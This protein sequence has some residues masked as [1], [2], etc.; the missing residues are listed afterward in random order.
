MVFVHKQNKKTTF[1]VE[2][3]FITLRISPPTM[4]TELVS[5]RGIVIHSRAIVLGIIH[6]I[7][8]IVSGLNTVCERDGS[9]VI[10][11][12]VACGRAVA[13][14]VFAANIFLMS[15]F[16]GH[17]CF[18]TVGA[19]VHLFVHRPFFL[20]LTRR[21]VRL[22]HGAMAVLCTLL[23]RYSNCYFLA[24]GGAAVHCVRNNRKCVRGP[25]CTMKVL[26][27]HLACHKCILYTFAANY[28]NWIDMGEKFD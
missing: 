22:T 12:I 26:E 24:R 27:S 9:F 4:T 28:L 20:L 6:H 13:Q 2:V 17:L 5:L 16:A 3:K 18:Y 7:T 19:F 14:T 1:A 11:A 23:A 21:V 8:S 10:T 15:F 25:E